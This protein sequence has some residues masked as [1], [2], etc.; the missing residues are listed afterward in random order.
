MFIARMAESLSAA[1]VNGEDCANWKFLGYRR[2]HRMAYV[3]LWLR[4]ANVLAVFDD[5]C[6]ESCPLPRLEDAVFLHL[7]GAS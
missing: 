7:D 6:T 3:G 4:A 5:T 2:C 1:F